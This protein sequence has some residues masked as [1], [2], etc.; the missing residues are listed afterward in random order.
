M[1][2]LDLTPTIAALRAIKGRTRRLN[3]GCSLHLVPDGP[4]DGEG[5]QNA[6]GLQVGRFEFHKPRGIG[7]RTLCQFTVAARQQVG[8]TVQ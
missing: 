1:H 4:R 8:C 7:Q 3:G 5:L 6:V 2:G